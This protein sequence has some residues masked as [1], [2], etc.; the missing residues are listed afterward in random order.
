MY[1]ESSN[2]NYPD[3]RADMISPTFD[4]SNLDDVEVKF[5]YHMYN[6]STGSPIMGDLHL[7][8]FHNN[9][10]IEDVMTPISENQGDQW[11]EQVVDLSAYDGEIVK[12]RF[13]GITGGYASDICIDDF[14]ING[15]AQS[16]TL[17]V[18]LTAFL[19]GPCTGTEMST[20]LCA[21][22]SIPLGQ[23]FFI[24]PWFYDGTESALIMPGNAVDWV[25]VELR[26]AVSAVDATPATT[27]ARQ[28]GLLLNDGSIVATDGSSLL[29]FDN[30]ISNNLFTVINHRNHLTIM[31]ANAVTLSGD[32]YTYDFTTA[33]EQAYGTNSQ[34]LLSSGIFGMMSGDCN[35]N[36]TVGNEDL[37]PGWETDAGKAGYYSADLN[38]DQQVN[39]IDKEDY[40]LPN[41]GEGTNVPQ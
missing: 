35:A 37:I 30:T 3:K 21:Y 4:L 16:T 27:I 12:L 36:G 25:L 40:W 10:W 26:D 29:S 7:D 5:W 9:V 31:S 15:N 18:D 19:E 8:V 11:H 23:P 28:A 41:V 32:N 13:R 34:K 1:T 38:F 39:N 14:S 17:I 20:Y 33:S 2:P 22:N 6:N 24:A